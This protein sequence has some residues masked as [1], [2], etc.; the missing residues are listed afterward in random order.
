MLFFSPLPVPPP[1]PPSYLVLHHLPCLRVFGRCTRLFFSPFVRSFVPLLFFNDM[2]GSVVGR[3]I[4]FRS[5]ESRVYS[6][7]NVPLCRV[8][9]VC[10]PCVCPSYIVYSRAAAAAAAAGRDDTLTVHVRSCTVVVAAA[11]AVV[12]VVVVVAQ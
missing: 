4:Q 7:F 5:V 10:V 9:A 6:F 2:C 12:V 11:A 3:L 1:P 8:C